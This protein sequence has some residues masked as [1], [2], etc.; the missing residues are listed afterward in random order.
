VADYDRG[1]TAR[2][3]LTVKDA[4]GALTDPAALTL[5]VRPPAGAS[6]VYTSPAAPIV[7]DATGTYHADIPLPT[8]GAW[9]Y[10][11]Q[12]TA[13]GQVQ[14]GTL[15]VLPAPLDTPSGQQIARSRLAR[16]TSADTEPTLDAAA[17][18][19][20]LLLAR[21]PDA[22]GLAATDAAWDP[23]YD[24]NLAAAEGWRWKAAKAASSYAFTMDGDSPERSFLMIRCEHMAD[25]YSKKV[26]TSVPVSTGRQLPSYIPLI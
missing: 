24:L 15:E 5:T 12:S 18:D 4:A 10:Q 22:A 14:G 6:T 17:L 11:W 16:M 19:D 8:A 13:P 9:T 25:Q 20:L 3:N 2:L 23:T 1:D 21:I 26:V 7:K